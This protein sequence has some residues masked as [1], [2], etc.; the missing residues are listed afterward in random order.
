MLNTTVVSPV[1]SNC[2]LLDNLE[3]IIIV[4]LLRGLLLAS[5]SP[6]F[7][8]GAQRKVPAELLASLKLE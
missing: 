4:A 1:H 2:E 3:G 5:E 6:S 7:M 8:N